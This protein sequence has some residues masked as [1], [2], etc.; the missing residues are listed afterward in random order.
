MVVVDSSALIPLSRV[1]R[2]DRI[3][4]VFDVI[5]T[6]AHVRDEV[7]MEG[8]RGTAALSSFLETVSVREPPADAGKV[9]T[10]EGIAAAD[11]GLVLL[12]D[13][14]TRYFSPTTRA[15]SRSPAATVSNAGG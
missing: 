5:W 15:S 8:K 6:T 7:M 13:E 10:L 4:A 9:A 1:G 11:A 2:L 14:R 12:A 3:P